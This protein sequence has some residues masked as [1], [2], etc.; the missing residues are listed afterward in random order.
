MI[1]DQEMIEFAKIQPLHAVIE[2]RNRVFSELSN[3]EHWIRKDYDAL[4]EGYLFVE[5]MLDADLLKISVQ[6]IAFADE[7]EQ[8]CMI[9]A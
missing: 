2:V 3:R 4:I 1:V 7:L 5:S 8:D 9:N 6:R